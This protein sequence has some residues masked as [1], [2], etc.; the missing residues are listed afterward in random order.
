VLQDDD[1]TATGTVR[2]VC[3]TNNG[4]GIVTEGEECDDGNAVDGD[5]CSHDFQ[6]EG[7]FECD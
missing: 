6:I 3:V 7:G 2:K 1:G 4:D 5:G